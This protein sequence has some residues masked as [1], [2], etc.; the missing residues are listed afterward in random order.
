MALKLIEI[1]IVKKMKI[2]H[3]TNN[4]EYL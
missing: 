2:E 1:K 3:G 4:G